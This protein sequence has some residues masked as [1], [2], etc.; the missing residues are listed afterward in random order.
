MT[1]VPVLTGAN[2]MLRPARPEDVAQRLALGNDPDIMRMFGV[3][4]AGI[5]PLTE[6]S[7]ARWVERLAA[8][9]YAWVVEHDSRLLGEVRLDGL[10]PHDARARLAIGLYDPAKLGMGLGREV[11]CLVVAHAFRHFGTSSD[12]RAGGCLQ[13]P[14]DP[15]LHGLRFRCRRTRA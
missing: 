9:P 7:A 6:A 5:R 8:H 1:T 2:V 4:P 15:L 12:Q 3:D 10:D 11:V 14:S 13:H